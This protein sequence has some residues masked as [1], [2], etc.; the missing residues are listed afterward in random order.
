MQSQLEPGETI[1]HETR[2]N[3]GRGLAAR[4]GRLTLTDHRLVFEPLQIG[5][6]QQV[7]EIPVQEIAS[8]QRIWLPGPLGRRLVRALEVNRRNGDRLVFMVRRPMRWHKEL[9][10]HIT[11]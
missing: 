2:A 7:I 1:L 10:P 6:P 11:G 3:L 4:Q 5:S 8:A 9:A